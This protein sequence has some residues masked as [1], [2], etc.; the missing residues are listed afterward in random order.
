MKQHLKIYSCDKKT[1][2]GCNNDGGYVYADIG[3]VYDCYI[4]AG[5]SDEESFSKHFI[6]RYN[7]DYSNSFAFDGTIVHYPY[8]YT[9]NISFI[10]KNIGQNNTAT[11]TNLAHL[12]EKYSN[13]FLKMDIE[14]GEYEWIPGAHMNKFAQIVIE[15]HD[16]NRDEALL[17]KYFQHLNQTHY[18]IH[19]HGNNWA[20][21]SANGM[22]DVIE[23]T[24]L[25]K[26]FFAN[27]P[28][29]FDGYLPDP[30]LDQ[31]NRAGFEDILLSDGINGPLA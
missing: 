30:Y 1:R 28:V 7:M 25:H 8:Q 11:T 14:G 15:F 17:S 31:P 4:S 13:I 5:V 22:P 12:M 6:E 20:G 10:Q 29:K 23:L 24:Y 19:A 3:P 27:T 16:I 2:G 9:T 21:V 18:L 26:K